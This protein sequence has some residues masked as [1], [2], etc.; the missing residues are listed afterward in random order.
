MN[1]LD[2]NIKAVNVKLTKLYSNAAE[3]VQKMMYS[4]N[5]NIDNIEVGLKKIWTKYNVPQEQENIIMQAVQKSVEDA[6]EVKLPV[7]FRKYYSNSVIIEGDSL[8]T[9]IQDV[10]RVEEIAATVRTAMQI[11]SKWNRIAVD[12]VDNKL[13]KADLPKYMDDLL[14]TGRQAAKISDDAEMYM[15]YRAKVDRVIEKIDK[16]TD[17]DKSEL[18]Q[19]YRNLANL[20]K[21]A[22]DKLIQKTVDRAIMF[23]ARYNAQRLATTE[24]ARAYGNARIYE[25]KNDPDATGIKWVLSGVHEHYDECNFFAETDMYGMGEGVFPK[26]EV[27]EYPAH[28][29]C[30]CI[31]E[32]VY[33]TEKG[34]Y[35]DE[36]AKAQFDNLDDED[37]KYLVGKEGSWDGFDWKN[38]EVPLNFDLAVEQEEI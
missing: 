5:T 17:S 33:D 20:S 38:H 19:S 32:P 22:S 28:P 12:M 8:S 16:L 21:D 3:E 14:Q 11:E 15:A 36:E 34:K 23:K 25:A 4:S 13:T 1:K 37:K 26:D 10:S 27:P 7:S 6:G 18:A 2:K 24:L 30:A 31:L 29:W 35:D 9:K